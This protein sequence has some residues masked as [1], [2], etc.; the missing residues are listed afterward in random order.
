M[1]CAVGDLVTARPSMLPDPSLGVSGACKGLMHPQLCPGGIPGGEVARAGVQH[2]LP[3]LSPCPRGPGV[4]FLSPRI[5][6]CWSP[7]QRPEQGGFL[8]LAR[9]F[10]GHRVARWPRA[11]ALGVSQRWLLVGAGGA[12]PRSEVASVGAQQET[13][14]EGPHLRG[15]C[16]ICPGW[17]RLHW[18]RAGRAG[19]RQC[20]R[21]RWG[22]A[23]LPKG[24]N[25]LQAVPAVFKLS[26]KPKHFN[27]L[28]LRNAWRRKAWWWLRRGCGKHESPP[29]TSKTQR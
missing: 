7:A 3:S 15:S 17:G 23:G 24:G 6:P 25:D 5:R 27:S 14:Q 13:R 20:H 19:G 4:C 12:L 10:T 21:H 28:R 26:P 11:P 9:C 29:T 1:G 16:P 8:H 18:G 2:T 22:Q